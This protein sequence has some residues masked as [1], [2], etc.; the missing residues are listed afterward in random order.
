MRISPAP[1]SLLAACAL[2]ATGCSTVLSTTERPES[3]E[4]VAVDASPQRAYDEALTMAFDQ[5]YRIAYASEEERLIE[6]EALDR[7]ILLPDHVHRI[8][9]F[10]PRA[11]DGRTFVHARYH[12]FETGDPSDID[13]RESDREE[14]QKLVDALVERL[15][16]TPA[17]PPEGRSGEENAL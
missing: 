8:D 3:L 15:G 1:L 2:L 10:F 12:S 7:R 16:G 6:L 5:G 11:E 4:P 17:S 13:V 9:L 14:A